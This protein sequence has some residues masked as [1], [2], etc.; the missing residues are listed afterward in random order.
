MQ[1]MS[2]A[3]FVCRCQHSRGWC[4]EL[5]SLEKKSLVASEQ[6]TAAVQQQR[7]EYRRQLQQIQAQRFR[8]IDEAGVNRA[9]SRRYARA[10]RG[11]RAHGHAP[12]NYGKNLTIVAA[13][14]IDGL[15][16]A[17]TIPGA[18]NGAAFIAYVEQVLAP[19]L[20]PGEIVVMDNLSSH[21]VDGV[22]QAI[23]SC[24]A[25]LVYLP[26]YSPD[27][28]PI[29]KCWS[30]IKTALR[31]AAARTQEALEQALVDAM[32]SIRPA[33]AHGWF[34]HCGYPVH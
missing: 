17:M 7:Q 4:G 32:S 33:D 10:M 11:Q 3:V 6:H 12:L 25:E 31:G 20:K 24:G 2:T 8:F 16:A 19:T 5:A 15:S 28:N 30:K 14:G 29:E 13:L 27:L 23:E 1:S 26:R 22:R 34:R 18:I 21:K 9:M